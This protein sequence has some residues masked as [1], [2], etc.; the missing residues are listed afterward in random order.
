MAQLRIREILRALRRHEVNFIV[1]GGISAVL[2]GAPLNTFD[3]DIVHSRES[4][5]VQ[6]LI[7]ALREME[8]VYRLQSQRKLSPSESHLESKGHQLLAT[9]FGPL[10]VLGEIGHSRSYADL[11]PLSFEWSPEP[12]NDV[13]VLGLETHILVKEEV[14]APKDLA[15]LPVLRRTLEERS[16]RS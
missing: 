2:Q 5:N 15:V 13:R 1:V 9:K 8:A 7:L 12:G 16:R 14:A 6:R 4:G 3:L 10:D 11:L